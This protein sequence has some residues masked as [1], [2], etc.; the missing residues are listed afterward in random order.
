MFEGANPDS[1]PI[2]L[3]SLL[4]EVVE[5]DSFAHSDQLYH[6]HIFAPIDQYIARFDVTVSYAFRV[7]IGQCSQ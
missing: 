6:Y 3:F 2:L 4:I 7:A 1:K 5:V